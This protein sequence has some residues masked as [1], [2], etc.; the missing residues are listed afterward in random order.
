MIR[1]PPR[2][3]L[4]PYTTLFRSLPGVATRGSNVSGTKDDR[5]LLV[6]VGGDAQ[7]RDTI[8]YVYDRTLGC[9][10]LNTQT[11]QVGGAWGP[12]G[13]Y[14]GDKGLL[15]HNARI[16]RGGRWARLTTSNGRAGQ[17]FWD[18]ESLTLTACPDRGAPNF[19][20]GHQVMGFGVGI[21][22]R[23]SGDAMDLAIRPM[24]SPNSSRLFPGLIS[25]LLT[26]PPRWGID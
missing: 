15:L 9:R 2:S 22:Q 19:C 12:T 11:G 26:T 16:S 18:I 4:F 24:A 20:N 10:W 7:D 13:A 5:R 23:Q 14:T 8:V 3:T 1:R 6:Y 17:Y 25:P 21:N